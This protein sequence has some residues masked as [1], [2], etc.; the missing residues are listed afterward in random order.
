MSEPTPVE[1]LGGGVRRI[2]SKVLPTR[3]AAVD[4]ILKKSTND[5]GG[6]GDEE[7][8]KGQQAHEHDAYVRGQEQDVV[9]TDL[10]CMRFVKH[11]NVERKSAFFFSFPS[12]FFLLL[13]FMVCIKQLL[14]DDHT[15]DQS[16][17][18]HQLKA[19][20]QTASI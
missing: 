18:H 4:V 17:S 11:E 20:C 7:E 6:G 10:T 8:Q 19:A 15:L 14:L 9:Q 1:T 16:Q 12:R 3:L 2:S 13:R 5:G